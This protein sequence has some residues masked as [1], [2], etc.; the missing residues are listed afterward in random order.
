[1]HAE[2]T[3]AEMANEVLARQ[4]GYR[5]RQSGEPLEAALR[6][7]IRTEAGQQLC[8]LLEGVH[9][10]KKAAE[11]QKNLPRKR[12]EQRMALFVARERVEQ[13]IDMSM[14]PG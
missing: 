4:A 10:N 3:V 9:R 5:A 8:K 2:Q 13:R 12:V 1:M 14:V 7:V 11:W 6:A